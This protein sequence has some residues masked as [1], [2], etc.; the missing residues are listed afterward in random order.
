MNYEYLKDLFSEEIREAG[1]IRARIK[2][3]LPGDFYGKSSYFLEKSGKHIRPLMLF[4]YSKSAPVEKK[5]ERIK[6]A[7]AVE[8]IHTA[9]LIHDDII[10]EAPKRRSLETLHKRLGTKN[11]VLCGDFL[12]TEALNLAVE[13]GSFESIRILAEETGKLIKGE[14]LESSGSEERLPSE[15]EYEKLIDLK[16]GSLFRAS[17]RI[18]QVLNGN[19][20]GT[21]TASE[22]GDLFGRAF[23]ILDDIKD[24]SKSDSGKEIYIDLRNSVMT[25]PVIHYVENNGKKA[26]REFRRYLKEN[27]FSEIKTMLSKSGA[28]EYSKDKAKLYLEKCRAICPADIRSEFNN[29]IS[30]EKILY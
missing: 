22:F 27:K 9:S 23:Q 28:F 8:L 30:P 26:E 11:S 4:L 19:E 21:E 12:T 17:F 6:M 14:I 5:T 16:T 7:A 13:S 25:L 2:K 24:F 18:A 20:N 15:K 29:F 1:K 10:D 3:G